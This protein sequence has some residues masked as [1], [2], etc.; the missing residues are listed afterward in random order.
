MNSLKCVLLRSKIICLQHVRTCFN[1]TLN[2]HLM[3]IPNRRLINKS[4][5]DCEYYILRN[6]CVTNFLLTNNGKNDI[7][8]NKHKERVKR[9]FQ[10]YLEQ[11]RERLRDTEQKFK[12][13][14]DI[15][16]KDIKETKDKVKEKV[17]EIIEVIYI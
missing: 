6:F 7:I 12:D 8:L 14:K 15:I 11:N 4:I 17:E 3:K 9:E 13:K 16:L 5:K 10:L 2:P 1:C